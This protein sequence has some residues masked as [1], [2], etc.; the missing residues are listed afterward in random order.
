MSAGT[1]RGVADGLA[2]SHTFVPNQGYVNHDGAPP[3]RTLKIGD[4]IYDMGNLDIDDGD[5]P[6]S[7]EPYQDDPDYREDPHDLAREDLFDPETHPKD[8]SKAYNRQ[9]RLDEA[10]AN[11]KVPAWQYPKSNPQPQPSSHLKTSSAPAQVDADMNSQPKTTKD[12]F[13]A[14]SARKTKGARGD[15]LSVPYEDLANVKVPNQM[16]RDKDKADTA[17]VEQVLDP[18]TRLVL[19]DMI[20]DD[21]VT[22]IQ[23][24]ISTG[25]EANVYY[26]CKIPY[27]NP[28]DF[29]A[30]EHFAIK[31]YKTAI[32][33]FKDRDKYVRGE[34]RF[35][36]GYKGRG[37]SSRQMVKLWAEKEMRNLKRL[38]KAGIPSPEPLHLKRNVLMMSFIGQGRKGK[39]APRLKDVKF[40]DDVADAKW[41]ASYI[42][43]VAYIRIMLHVCKLIH[44]DLSEYNMLY[45]EDKT[46]IIDVSQSVGFDHPLSRDF[47]RMDVKNVT[48]FYRRKGV[49]T[50][51]TS[52]VYA[53]VCEASGNNNYSSSE[54]PEALT[55]KVLRKE[56]DA[57]MANRSEADEPEDELEE[58]VFQTQFI[59]Q[60]LNEVYDPERDAKLLEQGGRDGLV[61][62]DLLAPLPNEK[63]PSTSRD[64][65][66]AGGVRLTNASGSED[67]EDASDDD[68]SNAE[69]GAESSGAS[70]DSTPARPRGKRFQDKAE[71]KAHKQQVK[72]EKREKRTTK[73]PKAEKKRLVKDSRK[74]R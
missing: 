8:L 74:R 51:P 35:G 38:N 45:F 63:Q 40:D 23:G 29:A 34:W 41:R 16:V 52:K 55:L 47:L 59:P 32:L 7:D 12:P 48:D 57:M 9:R 11:P 26:A 2:P 49:N 20:N 19:F 70:S 13:A 18:A 15:D 58:A 44:A 72:E 42:D 36:K 21:L 14:E 69:S 50:L 67:G 25:K 5:D 31:I 73:M 60:Y 39:A 62:K 54:T 68:D 4:M 56:V 28:D 17:T 66:E 6:E 71:K 10:A 3:R 53:W 64:P 61:Y 33:V 27:E 1:T 46:Y 65:D 37:S 24:T 30:R 22:E 43:A